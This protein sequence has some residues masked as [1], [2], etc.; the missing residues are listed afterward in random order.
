MIRILPNPERDRLV[1]LGVWRGQSIRSMAKDINKSI[2]TVQQVLHKLIE[3]GLVTKIPNEQWKRVY[4]VTAR[5]E[6][7]LRH[8]NLIR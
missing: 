4:S 2:G 1:L 7:K 3:D 5:G 6:E 8:D